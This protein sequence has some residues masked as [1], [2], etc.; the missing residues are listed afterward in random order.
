[1]AGSSAPSASSRRGGARPSRP[2]CGAASSVSSCV[3]PTRTLRP[4]DLAPITSPSGA[5]AGL[6]SDVARAPASGTGRSTARRRLVFV[7]LQ[8][9]GVRCAPDP[10][11]PAVV[12]SLTTFSSS[13]GGRTSSGPAGIRDR[14]RCGSGRT[15]ARTCP[16]SSSSFFFASSTLFAIG[17][18]APSRGVLAGA[19]DA[20]HLRPV[21][22]GAL[23]GV[24]WLEGRPSGRCAGLGAA[25]R[26]S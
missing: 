5:R 14:R 11:R 7:L 22:E 21:N 15:S 24:T 12:T 9:A 26:G 4:S 3:T 17:L 8:R 20:V 13:S 16:Y 10:T 23:G 18:H 2:A 19:G 25:V 1:M 6:R